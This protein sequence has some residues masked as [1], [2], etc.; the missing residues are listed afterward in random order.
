MLV[1][2]D[3]FREEQDGIGQRFYLDNL[4][5]KNSDNGE[6][7]RNGGFEVR[8]IP[9]RT[10]KI[11]SELHNESEVDGVE[12]SAA[13]SY[14]GDWSLHINH[15][16]LDWYPITASCADFGM[17]NGRKY[18]I[19]FYFKGDIRTLYITEQGLCIADNKPWISGTNYPDVGQ[20]V[21]GAYANGWYKFEVKDYILSSENQALLFM[22]DYNGV[23][24]FYLDNLSIIESGRELVQNGSFE[25]SVYPPQKEMPIRKNAPV[26]KELL[27]KEEISGVSYSAEEAY[28][29]DWAVHV[30]KNADVSAAP[31]A[32]GITEGKTYNVSFYIK[33]NIGNLFVSLS[34][35]NRV[36]VTNDDI[37]SGTLT[38]IKKVSV[39]NGWTKVEI[40]NAVVEKADWET[41][42][43]VAEYNPDFYIDKLSI[44]ESNTELVE[45][46]N[47][48]PAA[49]EFGELYAKINSDETV[50]VSMDVLKHRDEEDYTAPMLIFASYDNGCLTSCTT[51][52]ES[53]DVE[54][55][56]KWTE[57]SKTVPI[58]ADENMNVYL[59][60]SLES[61]KPLASAVEIK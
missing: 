33:G 30:N 15:S 42:F 25:P 32:F 27:N 36:L 53:I 1:A 17:K 9:V 28:D 48:E 59:W 3:E 21:T 41:A 58:K 46:G 34:G 2:I 44:T 5:I 19:S 39:E 38:D 50:T 10:D 37:R 55:N 51:V 11:I 14:D 61:L 45:N 60:E 18:D 31:S 13:E 40:N 23:N 20:K 35:K 54:K 4:S 47:F 12:Y 52:N 7:V 26:I 8:R 16:N 43:L 6:L 57:I 29:G 24:N 22:Q 49:I 56:N